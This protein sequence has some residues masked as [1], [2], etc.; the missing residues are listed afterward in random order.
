MVCFLFPRTCSL[1]FQVLPVDPVNRHTLC[2]TN[3]L[4]VRHGLDALPPPTSPLA[5][6]AYA[7]LGVKPITLP[8]A[9]ARFAHTAQV[10]PLFPLACYLP[11]TSFHFPPPHTRTPP[12]LL[13]P[14]L[15]TLCRRVSLM[16]S[17]LCS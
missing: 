7:P 2:P 12:L 5:A 6:P 16:Q 9:V 4:L 3:P 11:V 13:F 10:F 17:V 14:L 1:A 15:A 8:A